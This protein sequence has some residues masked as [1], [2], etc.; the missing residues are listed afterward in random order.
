MKK[1]LIMILMVGLLMGCQTSKPEETTLT[2]KKIENVEYGSLFDTKEC[3]N[4]TNGHIE[5]YPQLDTSIIGIHK[6]TFVVE[7]DQQKKSFEYEIEVKDTQMPII[8]LKKEKDEI[9]YNSK[10]DALNYINAV[11]DLVDGDIQYKKESEVKSDDYLYYTYHSDVNMKKAGTYTIHYTAVDKNK[12]KTEKD[13]KISVKEEKKEPIQKAKSQE[14]T[15]SKEKPDVPTQQETKK[16]ESKPEVETSKE[17]QQ[18]DYSYILPSTIAK[19]RSAK[20]ANKIVTVTSTSSRSR[21]GIVQ[22]FVKNGNQWIEKLKV[23]CQL[24]KAGM[25]QGSEYSTRTPVGTYHFTHAYGIKNNP[26]SKMSYTQINEHHYWCGDQ[27]YNQFVDDTV[28][29]HS[30]CSINNDEHLIDYPGS[31]NYFASFNYNSGNVS[32]VGSAYFLHCSKGSYTMGCIGIPEAKMVYLLQN[33]DTSTILIVDQVN[34][35][36]NH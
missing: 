20:N 23:N 1:G 19:T 21:K 16:P 25:G 6:L 15:I 3:V 32:G 29:D 9:E 27:Y 7:K 26:G 5:E 4:E 24:G 31:Y 8:E 18:S 17:P 34:N 11:K 12:N 14:T 22:Y 33:I 13:L 35:V 10:Y 2:F 36:V 28:T 30:A